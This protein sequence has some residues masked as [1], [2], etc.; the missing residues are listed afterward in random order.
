LHFTQSA[1]V[2]LVLPVR[3]KAPPGEMVY[4]RNTWKIPKK[5][6]WN[7]N[8]LCWHWEEGRCL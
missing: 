2:L 7:K 8:N 1:F 5:Y 4:C 3:M 6:H